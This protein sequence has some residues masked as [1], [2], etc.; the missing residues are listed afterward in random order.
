MALDRGLHRGI[1]RRIFDHQ[2]F[3]RI[4]RGSALEFFC[5]TGNGH[6]LEAGI[7]A[8]TVLEVH[9]PELADELAAFVDAVRARY[10]RFTLSN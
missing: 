10:P 2:T 7:S 5:A 9:D 8:D 3:L 6:H 4:D 1:A